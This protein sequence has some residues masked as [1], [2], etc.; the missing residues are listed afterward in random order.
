MQILRRLASGEEIQLP[1][2]NSKGEPDYQSKERYPLKVRLHYMVGNHDWYY[3]LQGEAFD[4]VRLELIQKMGLSNPVSP[5]PYEADESP[6]LKDLFERH[7]VFARHGDIYDRF[8][9]NR[10]KGRNHSTI[11]DAFT[12]DVCNRFPIEVQKRYGEK[13]T[14]WHC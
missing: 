2:A 13:I 11:G 3:R 5:F 7:K 9:F 1:P 14:K 4:R 10:E 12:M 8:N 6:I